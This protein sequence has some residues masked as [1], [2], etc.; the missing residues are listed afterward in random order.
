MIVL[1]TGAGRGLGRHLAEKAA[2]AGHTVLAGVRRPEAQAEALRA[3][4]RG[5]SGRIHP[6]ALDVADEASVAAAAREVRERFGR[7]DA[8]VNN[9]GVLLARDRTIEQLDFGDVERTMQV[10]LYGPMRVAKHFVPLLREAAEKPAF[11]NISSEAGSY[12]GAYGG[13]YPYALSKAALNY[14]SAQLRAYLKDRD[15]AVYAVH[16]GWIRTDMGGAAAPGD[17]AETA[18][19]LLALIER[20]VVPQTEQVFVD[21]RGK[22]MPL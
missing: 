3:L 13:D 1:I 4:E 12:A 14:F 22:P 19:G 20:R 15:V 7:V 11:L 5:G 10:N 2:A 17:P 16:P 6:L 21:F 18:E 8:V 9:A